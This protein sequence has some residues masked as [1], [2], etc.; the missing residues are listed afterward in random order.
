MVVQFKNSF[1]ITSAGSAVRRGLLGPYQP[2]VHCRHARCTTAVYTIAIRK[3]NIVD[4]YDLYW[5]IWYVGCISGAYCWKIFR[6]VRKDRF[7]QG[8]VSAGVGTVKLSLVLL[9][10]CG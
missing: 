9:P 4:S 6:T 10:R 7:E 8:R 2:I 1:H 3:N 5:S